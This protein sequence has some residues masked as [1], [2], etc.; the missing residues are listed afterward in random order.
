M[1]I[2]DWGK[3]AESSLNKQVRTTENSNDSHAT[4][5]GILFEH[6]IEKLLAAMFPEETWKR[7]GE[8][9]DG[10]KDFV[11]PAEEYL[12]EQKWAECKNYN[13]NLSINVI[14]PT[15]IMGA[16]KEIECI[17]F[18]SYSPLND[19]AIENLLCYS[20]ME[21]LVIRIFDGNLLESLICKYH[22]VN[23]LEEFFPNTDF[24][25]ARVELEKTPLRII[26]TLWDL[27]GNKVPST[28]RF[29]LGESFYYHVTIQNLTWK[30]VDYE[31]SFRVGNQKV[32]HC[33]G[34][35]YKT[36]LPFAEI[37][38][39]SALCETLNPGNTRCIAKVI[40]NDIS[41]SVCEAIS[42]ID[43]PYLAWSGENALKAQEDGRQHLAKKKMQPLII[44][45]QSGT[46][47]STLTEIL[48]QQKQ[49][50]ESYQ[51]LKVDLTLARN[52][53]MRN[54]LSQIFGMRGKE[55]TPKEQTDDEEVALSLLI[56]AYAESAAMIAQAMMKFY[57]LDRPYLFVIED[58]Q[59]I[60][61]PYISLIRELDGQSQERNCPIY[62]LFTLN[63][64]KTSLD[65]LLSQLDWD[66]NYQNRECRI[67]RTTNFR[68]KDILGYIKTRYGLEDIDSY[69]DGF[70][71]EVTPL[72]LHAFCAG[73]QK[74]RVIAPIPGKKTY[75]IIR[76]FQFSDGVQQ[77]LYGE[78][79][80]KNICKQLDKGGQAEFLLKYLYIADTFTI[81]MVSKN[82]SILQGLIDQGIL[83]EK[84]GFITFY[85][86]KIRSVLGKELAFSEEDYA[87]IFADNDTDDAAKAICALE[88][89]GYLRNGPTF[90]KSFFVSDGRIRKREQRY[91]ICWLIIQYLKKLSSIGLCST[92][93]KFVRKQF[94]AL[95]EEQ[96]HKTFL[97]FLKHIADSAL[98][99]GWDIDEECTENIAF[100][101]KKFF[102]RALSTYN[103][104]N[105]LYYF[106]EFEKIFNK[107]KHISEGRRNFWLAHYANRAAIALDRRSA[108]L[109]VEPTEVRK[110]Y[111][112]SEF[113]SKQAD[114]RE[115]IT[116]QIVVDNFNRHYVYRHDLNMNNISNCLE[117][118]CQFKDNGM[119]G[120]MV[121]DYHLHLL[122]Y[123]SVQTLPFD[124]QYILDLLDRVRDAR[125]RSDSAFYTIKL[126]ILEITILASCHHWNEAN[127]CLSQAFVFAY[128]K[129]MR[130]YIYKL[131]YIRTH[132]IIFEKKNMDSPEVYQQAVLAL[133]QMIDT[134]GSMMQNLK[135]ES[136]LLVQLIRI[137]TY[138]DSNE[139]SSLISNYSQENQDLLNTI[140]AHIKGVPTEIDELLDMGS[141]FV[142]KGVNFPTI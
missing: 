29:E 97:T 135:R 72:E 73:L 4:N 56:G 91:Q 13:N 130:P 90:L 26:K 18:F 116:L 11:Y 66:K 102:D 129:E 53:C 85:H 27:N 128:K 68:K 43:E 78:I 42:V 98:E 125:Q 114:N 134:H 52:V 16:I 70:E 95:R 77:I 6:V 31:I 32:L 120:S 34:N 113:Y 123:M 131:T 57:N 79:P 138:F 23:G 127:E 124:E 51:V 45:G 24:E 133:E 141:F 8:S 3:I 94:P 75:Q 67:I 37:K 1:H 117:N 25:K 15:L 14:A 50:Q 139:I 10:K 74:E 63:E 19:T 142:V 93:L 9:H 140:C 89:I 119:E 36:A 46:G 111:E 109:T 61:R 12:K 5:K 35:T 47:K 112:L 22:A 41:K 110:M 2:L 103:D 62:Y 82:A 88:Q 54:L 121:L 105:C 99:E 80:L 28:H 30:P 7:T 59:K 64:K 71:K 21:R 126:Y 49:I 39:Y 20:E 100:F 118:L 40:T 122:E 96:S 48:L 65:E 108:P 33:A 87:D 107:L 101:I 136:F 17:F 58:I 76:P 69:F 55:V 106:L 137:I 132:L 60:T 84:D 81:K 86:D 115:Q 92:A 38:G 104:Q 83:R 44:V